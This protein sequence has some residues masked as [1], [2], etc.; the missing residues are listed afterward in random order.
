MPAVEAPEAAHAGLAFVESAPY[1]VRFPCPVT[2]PPS[3]VL[4]LPAF[5]SGMVRPV[6]K[7]T[8]AVHLR[9]EQV[10]LVALSLEAPDGTGAVLSAFNG[11]HSG[12][13]GTSCQTPTVFDD[14]ARLAINRARPPFAGVFRPQD[15]LSRYSAKPTEALNGRWNIIVSDASRG[16]ARAQILCATLTLYF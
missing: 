2:L 4:D 10:G 14:E 16:E 6:R 15:A 9:H 3:G 11:G 13:Y 7:L 8:V 1:I 5:V 12:S